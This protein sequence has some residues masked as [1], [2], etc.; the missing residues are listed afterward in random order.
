MCID[1]DIDTSTLLLS[2]MQSSDCCRCVLNDVFFNFDTVFVV[3][4]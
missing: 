3:M 1:I 2:Y 4:I